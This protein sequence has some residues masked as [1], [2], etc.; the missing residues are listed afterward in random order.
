MAEVITITNNGTEALEFHFFQYC[1]F[2]LGGDGSDDSVDIFNGNQAMQ[3]DPN[4]IVSETIVTG[5]PDSYE[6]A[7]TS[8]TLGKLTD[9]SATDLNNSTSA[10][11]GDVTWAFQWD[12]T[13]DPGMTFQISKDKNILVPEP[14]TMALLAFGGLGVLLKRKRNR[15]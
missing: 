13:I 4:Q 2:N 1:D 8:V 3:V 11:P 15:T 5:T 14:A 9:G 6:A 10:G 12:R 7:L